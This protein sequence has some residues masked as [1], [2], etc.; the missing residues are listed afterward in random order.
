[1]KTSATSSSINQSSPRQW[2]LFFFTLLYVCLEFGFNNQLLKISA[3]DLVSDDV[4]LGLEFWGRI[5]SGV[6]L[7]LVLYRTSAKIKL[8][9]VV[10]YLACLVAGI[11]V[12]WQF[13]TII[14]DY[15]VENA[16]LEDREMS[17]ILATLSS[18]AANGALT[19]ANGHS[20]FIGQADE[21]DRKVAASL[22][23]A[24]ALYVPNRL[25]QIAAWSEMSS[26]QIKGLLALN[27]SETR[28][29]NAYRN[30]IIPPLTLGIS[31]FFALLNLAQWFGMGLQIFQAR[32]GLSL[33]QI[34]LLTSA[35]FITFMLYSFTATS[36]FADSNA[37][38]KDL[39]PPLF[40]N[41]FVLAVLTSLSAHAVPNWYFFTSWCNHYVLGS[42]DLKRPY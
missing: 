31:I 5:L 17:L 40:T 22:F 24:A 16:S 3:I 37:F 7:S 36:A 38:Q 14:T 30:L 1:V 9:V 32:I 8:P 11:V 13:Q 33:L 29:S 23:P 41:H 39:A 6:G 28:L 27:D 15:L 42:M 19:T 25:A 18:K 10:R 4:L 26:D 20:F 34:R 12:M 21:Q 35:I 2:A